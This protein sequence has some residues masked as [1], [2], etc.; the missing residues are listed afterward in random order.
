MKTT[1]NDEKKQVTH[2]DSVR[3]TYAQNTESCKFILAMSDESYFDMVADLGFRFLHKHQLF[4]ELKSNAL[5]WK[6]LR[7]IVCKA[8]R[9]FLNRFSNPAKQTTLIISYRALVEF[10]VLNS[11]H[12]KSSFENYLKV[13]RYE[14]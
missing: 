3:S 2:I 4:D 1:T 11:Y 13:M 6:W 10:E 5:F 7:I 8:E 9:R 12:T 14:K